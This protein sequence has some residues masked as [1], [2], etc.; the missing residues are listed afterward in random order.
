[1]RESGAHVTHV[2]EL[3]SVV[4]PK[5][6][7][8]ETFTASAGLGV[9][10]D[11]ELLLELRLDLDPVAAA[12]FLILRIAFLADDTLEMLLLRLSEERFALTDDMFREENQLVVADEPLEQFLAL[13][14]RRFSQI[15]TIRVDE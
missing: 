12:P 8:A 4:R 10:A 6:Q 2:A 1:M 3:F 14:Q 11:D 5:Q 15:A 7:R 9:A 13:F